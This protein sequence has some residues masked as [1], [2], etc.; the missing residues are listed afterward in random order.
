MVGRM[1]VVLHDTINF[2]GTLCKENILDG[3]ERGTDD[4]CSSVYCLLKGLAV[5]CTTQ[6]V[7]TL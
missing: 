6:L 4:F 5:C 1:G 2:A 3:G 7:D